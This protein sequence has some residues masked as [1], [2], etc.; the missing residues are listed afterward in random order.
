MK[1]FFHKLQY[2]RD[3][4]LLFFI[5][6]N[7]IVVGLT[8]G[9]RRL[10]LAQVMEKPDLNCPKEK[11]QKYLTFVFFLMKCLWIRP[12]C[13]TSSIAVCRILKSR[14]F[15]AHIVFGCA[16]EKEKLKGHCW[17]ELDEEAKSKNYQPV[18]SYPM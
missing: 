11:L 13:F 5:I 3:I 12:S 17:V 2:Y 9:R 7:I 6:S 1:T 4:K 16:F 10:S 8:P 14:G 18:F 15:N